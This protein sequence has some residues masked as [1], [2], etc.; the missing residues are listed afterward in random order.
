MEHRAWSLCHFCSPGIDFRDTL[1]KRGEGSEV[2]GDI[3]WKQYWLVLFVPF[4]NEISPIKLPY[5]SFLTHTKHSSF[6]L[7]LHT[8]SYIQLKVGEGSKLIAISNQGKI[9]KRNTFQ[10]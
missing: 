5:I 7:S 6:R 1:R 2:S 9:F 10:L 3:K 8:F 4:E